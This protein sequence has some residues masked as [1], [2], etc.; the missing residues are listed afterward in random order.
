MN[1]GDNVLESN[2]LHGWGIPLRLLIYSII[3]LNL[4]KID[5]KYNENDP[6][7]VIRF[8]KYISS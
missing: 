6:R 3:I 5:C 8:G 2:Y 4:V 1:F 7:F